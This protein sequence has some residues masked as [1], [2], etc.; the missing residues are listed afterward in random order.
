MQYN[1]S[2]REKDGGW[3]FIIS[4]KNNDG[5]WKQ[6]SKQ[7]FEKSR[8]GKLEAKEAAE[9]A[10]DEL[11]NKLEIKYDLPEEYNEITF[12]KFM[13]KY[14]KHES[15][16]KEKNTIIAYNTM[17]GN[18]NYLDN[19]EMD[20]I[21][22]LDIQY[23]VDELIKKG[24][25]NSTIKIYLMRLKT[26]FNAAKKKYKII[27]ENPIENID[28]PTTKNKNEK[29]ALT[30]KELNDLIN[31]I[32]NKKYRIISLLAGKCGL[33]VGEILGLEWNKI[34]EKKCIIRVTQ[35][36]KKLKD[37]KQGIGELKSKNSKREVP[38]PSKVM[39]ELLKYKS[40]FPTNFDGR[41]FSNRCI[42]TLCNNLKTTY[43]KTGY[44][45]SIHELR[46]T[47]AT[48]L[49]AN[50]VDFKTA[51]KLL[52]HDIEQTMKTYSHVTSDMID[53]AS[54]IINGIF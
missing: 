23:C 29:T 21:K 28:M 25:E 41:I 1:I 54:K 22:S 24:L 38:I 36:W 40:E 12:S 5:K 10:I 4:Y 32:V 51:A 46:H 49:I 16:Y 11:K 19:M 50:G 35:Q 3:Q 48:L 31:K 9:K 30:K 27:M 26:V 52:G 20:E 17:S 43:K 34:D 7:G 6:K 42:E 45:I 53:S 8:K 18:F 37:G 14:I 39:K 44:E 47:Y 33:R 2:Y 15:L 13:D